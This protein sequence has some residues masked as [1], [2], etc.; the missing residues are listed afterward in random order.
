[1]TQ[2]LTNDQE[3]RAAL[4]RIRATDSGSELPICN[5]IA[6][7]TICLSHQSICTATWETYIVIRLTKNIVRCSHLSV[8]LA[9][10]AGPALLLA[11]IR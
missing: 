1:M 5:D 8:V 6:P 4:I 7:M 9:V 2:L 11:N 10:T 3:L